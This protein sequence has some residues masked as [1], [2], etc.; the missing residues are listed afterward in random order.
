M[1]ARP[2]GFVRRLGPDDQAAVVDF[3][4]RVRI[5]QPFAPDRERLQRAIRVTVADAGRPRRQA[6]V[7]LS[8]G[9]DTSSV[10]QM[11]DVLDLAYRSDTT[12]YSVGLGARPANGRPAKLEAEFVLRR[13]ANPS[14]GRAFVPAEVRA[15]PGIYNEIRDDQASQ[16]ALAYASTNDRRDGQWRRISVRLTQGKLAARTKPGY[17]AAR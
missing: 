5:L 6:I 9:E 4:S 7:L 16:Y 15:L 17:F 14:G 8:D 13:L 12:I 10:M 3:D 2:A 1:A 11:D